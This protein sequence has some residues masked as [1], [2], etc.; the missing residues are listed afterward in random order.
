VVAP[1]SRSKSPKGFRWKKY[2]TRLP[3]EQELCDWFADREDLGLAVIFGEV[4]G[5]LACRDFDDVDGYRRWKRFH[6]DLARMLPTVE[7]ARGRHVYF[8][9]PPSQHVFTDLRPKEKGEYRGDSKHYC[10]LPP[11]QHPDGPEYRWLVPLPEGDVRF[12]EDVVGAGLFPGGSETIFRGVDVTQ[13]AQG[14]HRKSQVVIIPGKGAGARMRVSVSAQTAIEE[15]MARSIPTAPG[16][17]RMKLLELARMLKFM[18]EFA[19]IPATRIGFLKPYLKRWWKMAK[20][21]T[22]GKHPHFWTSWQDFVFAWEE[23]RVPFGATMQAIFDKARS[24]PAPK[25]AVERYGDGSLR[26]LLASLCRELQRF[27]GGKSFFL[28]GRTAGPLMGVS[29]V[30]AW[31][32]LKQLAEDHIIDPLKKHPR[33]KRLATEFCYLPDD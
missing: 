29:D 8:R 23:A 33:G 18:P 24:T 2:Q 22:S 9:A 12:I 4:S 16:T 26:A 28:T 32:W 20:P 17:R 19:D 1:I 10:L 31:R 7:T 13:K 11:S 14:S 25:V 30:H 5:G 27:N 6:P 15:A 3:T 21:H